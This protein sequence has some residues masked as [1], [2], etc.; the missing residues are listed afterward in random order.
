MTIDE[1]SDF[2]MHERT[3]EEVEGFLSSQSLGTLG[4]S[5]KTEPY[6]IPI[7]Y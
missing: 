6:L 4:L 3:D 5:T 2:G 7:S 1:L